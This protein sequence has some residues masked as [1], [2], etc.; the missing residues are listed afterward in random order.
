MKKKLV[1]FAALAV[2]SYPFASSSVFAVGAIRLSQVT[3]LIGSDTLIVNMPV[4]FT[5]ELE[6]NTGA[7]LNTFISGFRVFTNLS[8][9]NPFQSGYFDAI[10]FDTLAIV[11]SWSSAFELGFFFNQ[12]NVD[13]IGADTVGFKAFAFFES[14]IPTG[15]IQEVWWIETTPHVPGDTLC[16]DSSTYPPDNFWIWSTTFGDIIPFW[17]GP[18]CYYIWKC[19]VGNRGDLNGDGADADILDLTHLVDFI[20]RGS[21]DS[22]RCPNESDV[23]RDGNPANILDLTYLVD[24]IF[25]GGPVPPGC[26]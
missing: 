18:H 6:Q 26:E 2:L 22:G 7:D 12:Q 1:F 11:P 25:R 24:V 23:N 14:G 9:S 3:G 20:F 8:L 10:T 13:G 16:I 15:F 19:C 17:D 21:G 5:F 4:R